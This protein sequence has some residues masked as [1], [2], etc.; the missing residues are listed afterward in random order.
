MPGTA[1][2]ASLTFV[3]G[4]DTWYITLGH[5]DQWV[6][7]TADPGEYD[8]DNDSNTNNNMGYTVSFSPADDAG[9]ASD[10]TAG[11]DDGQAQ[12]GREEDAE[13]QGQRERR[14]EDV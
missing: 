4:I 1:R 8:P 3:P 2:T 6:I 12:V 5:D 10:A 11:Y 13:H 9:D 14:H 7:V